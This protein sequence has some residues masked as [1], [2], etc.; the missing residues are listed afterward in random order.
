VAGPARKAKDRSARWEILRREWHPRRNGGLSIREFPI[1]FPGKVWWRCAKDPNH[2]WQA[3]I[4]HRLY[5]G[6]GCPSCRRDRWSLAR[7]PAHLLSEWHPSKNLP[8]RP[9]DVSRGSDRLVWWRCRVDHRHEW[10][11]RPDRR[12][13]GKRSGCHYCTGREV[14]PEGSLAQR[15][16]SLAA[17]WHP[18]KNGSLRPEQVSLYSKRAVWWRCPRGPDHVWKAVVHNR[19]LAPGC[20]FCRGLR[21]SVTNCVATRM[22]ELVAL[23]HPTKNGGRTP[24][25]TLPRAKGNICWRCPNGPDHEWQQP[26]RARTKGR[27]RCPFCEGRKLSVTNCLAT[28]YPKVAREW[29]PTRNLPL[30]PEKVRFRSPEKVWWRCV[31]G[32]EW[33]T[34][35]YH[36][37]QN[38]SGCPIC[39]YLSRS[40]KPAIKRIGSPKGP[41]PSRRV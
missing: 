10:Q 41:V 7:G 17:Q 8:L 21:V 2:E 25:N 26:A 37:T 12:A 24:W 35:V 6:T 1:R 3:T 15:R 4:G 32:H 38:E 39:F 23:W 9:E 16:P 28:A 27:A 40:K 13:S 31:S 36:R 30:T 29:H 5:A 22:P 11:A 34:T 14:S 20:V 18:S 19:A 33:R